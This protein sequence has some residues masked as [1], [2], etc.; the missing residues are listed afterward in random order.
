MS[1]CDVQAYKTTYFP[2]LYT[3]YGPQLSQMISVLFLEI[4]LLLVV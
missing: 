2:H 1:Y 4:E 3:G